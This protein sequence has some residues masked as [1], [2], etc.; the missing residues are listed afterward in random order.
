MTEWCFIND[1]CIKSLTDSNTPF[2]IYIQLWSVHEKAFTKCF[3]LKWE[4]S[5]IY[6]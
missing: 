5:D 3:Q 2:Q 6:F 4:R 1:N